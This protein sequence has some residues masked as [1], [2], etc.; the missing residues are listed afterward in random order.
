[1][2]IESASFHEGAEAISTAAEKV[3][4]VFSKTRF[5]PFLPKNSGGVVFQVLYS[6]S[7]VQR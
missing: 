2:L 3:L 7:S 5:Y 1:M 6:V 4:Q